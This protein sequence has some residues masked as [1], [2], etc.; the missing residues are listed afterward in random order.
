VLHVDSNGAH[1]QQTWVPIDTT[2]VQKFRE[3]HEAGVIDLQEVPFPGEDFRAIEMS[4]LEKNHESLAGIYPG[5]W[6]AI[7]GP[8]L[9]AHAGSIAELLDTA[10][11][12][13]HPNPFITAIP[14]D[15]TITLQ[16]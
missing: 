1:W 3:Q 14:S 6:I 10:R 11:A 4:W 2:T 7:D 9:V 12:A 13:G 15:P 8:Q 5:E 16:L